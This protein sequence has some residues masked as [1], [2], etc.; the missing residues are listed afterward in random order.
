MLTPELDRLRKFL[1]YDNEEEPDYDKLLKELE[2][3]RRLGTTGEVLCSERLS[4]S[5]GICPTCG[6]SIT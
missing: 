1:K 3:L 6:Q 4:V 5:S 2:Y